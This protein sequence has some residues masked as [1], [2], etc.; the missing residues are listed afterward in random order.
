[1][2]SLVVV[3]LS[4]VID[5]RTSIDCPLLTIVDAIATVYQRL[6]NRLST[7]DHRLHDALT[8]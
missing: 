5:S 2:Q 3:A 6:T 1:M 8:A 7:V 4:V